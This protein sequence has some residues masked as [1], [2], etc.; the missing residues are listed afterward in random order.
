M[1]CFHVLEKYVFGHALRK[2]IL[3]VPKC[4]QQE[5]EDRQRSDG[6]WSERTSCNIDESRPKMILIEEKPMSD[7]TKFIETTNILSDGSK[8]VINELFAKFS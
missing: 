5:F 4:P 6:Q 3:A 2:K 1:V 7:G 8:K